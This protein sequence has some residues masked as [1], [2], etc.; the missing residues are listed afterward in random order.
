MEGPYHNFV[1]NGIVVHNCNYNKEKFGKE[2]TVIEPYWFSDI[3]EDRRE[4]ILHT[5]IRD[6]RE[7]GKFTKREAQYASWW[8]GVKSAENAYFDMLEAG[9]TPEEARSVLPN[10][11]KTELVVTA[12]IREFRHFFK[13]RAAGTTG[14][15]HPQMAEVAVPLLKK[16]QEYMPELFGDIVVPQED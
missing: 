15:P 13:L 2:I 4:E 8:Y 5:R 14:K 11:L 10:S 3:D 12:N 1:A 9:A 16:C 7:S 6:L